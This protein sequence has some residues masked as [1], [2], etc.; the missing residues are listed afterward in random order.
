MNLDAARFGKRG[1][2]FNYGG[3]P[4]HMQIDANMAKKINGMTR[5]QL[6][7]T[8]SDLLSEQEIDAL[9]T[10]FLMMKQYIADEQE[11]D[12]SL[13]VQDWNEDTARREMLLAGGVNSYLNERTDQVGSGYSGNNYYQRQLLML[14]AMDVN[15]SNDDREVEFM[16]AA[17]RGGK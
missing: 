8:F 9:W 2:N 14:N 13:I 7:L 11:Q 6:V 15:H 12:P 16:V 17:A 1:D 4:G 10:R 3:M 5:N